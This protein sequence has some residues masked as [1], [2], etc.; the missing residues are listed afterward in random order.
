M[1]ELRQIGRRSVQAVVCTVA[2]A[3]ALVAAAAM[4]G[5]TGH[6]DSGRSTAGEQWQMTGGIRPYARC[7]A[8]CL[9]FLDERAGDLSRVATGADF[10]GGRVA[11]TVQI[12]TTHHTASVMASPT[13]K[14][15]NAT[16]WQMVARRQSRF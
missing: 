10:M 11:M 16:S 8:D 14:L 7:H 5:G 3:E 1:H 15:I 12:P 4:S 9:W 13:A 2:S 6:E